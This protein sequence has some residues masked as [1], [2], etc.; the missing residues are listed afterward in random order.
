M[1]LEKYREKIEEKVEK[2]LN[3]IL[4]KEDITVEEL[5]FLDSRLTSMRMKELSK[6]F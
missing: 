2:E 6:I 4:D 3:K 1:D 5:Q